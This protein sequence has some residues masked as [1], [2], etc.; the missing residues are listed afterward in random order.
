MA[1]VVF[2]PPCALCSL[3]GHIF[4]ARVFFFFGVC[5]VHFCVKFFSFCMISWSC[6]F[7][8]FVVNYLCVVSFLPSAFFQICLVKYVVFTVCVSL[9]FCALVVY[10]ALC[11]FLCPIFLGVLFHMSSLCAVWCVRVLRAVLFFFPFSVQCA[12][13]LLHN[14]PRVL[15]D[16]LFVNWVLCCLL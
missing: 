14:V 11:L 2:R 3:S 8:L 4:I 13:C 7:S 12:L 15:R 16:P 10:Y 5:H 6:D 9:C 1:N